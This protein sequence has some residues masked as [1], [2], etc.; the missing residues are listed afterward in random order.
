MSSPPR[1]MWSGLVVAFILAGFCLLVI[2]VAAVQTG[3]P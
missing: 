3:H 1:D 2:I